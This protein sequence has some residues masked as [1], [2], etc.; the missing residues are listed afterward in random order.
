MVKIMPDK[1]ASS[2]GYCTSGSLVCWGSFSHWL[3]DIDWNNVA[4]ISGILIGLATFAINWWYKHQALKTYRE[5]VARGD[6][7]PPPKM[8]D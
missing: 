8:G 4:V 1:I 6:T 3:H 2:V 7:V 5:S